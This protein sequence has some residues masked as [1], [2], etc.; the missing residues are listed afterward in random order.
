MTP[1]ARLEEAEVV[2]FSLLGQPV[3]VRSREPKVFSAYRRLYRRFPEI[4]HSPEAHVV[5][6]VKRADDD[7]HPWEALID[8]LPN[9]RHATLG[10]AMKRA[11]RRCC[12]H[13][14][15]HTPEVIGLHAAT[16]A[17]G[18]EFALI[19]GDSGS[20][21]TTLTLTL[22]ARGYPVDG[23]DIALL[24]PTT[25]L[26]RGMPRCFHLDD[27][28]IDLLAEQGLVVREREI[29]EGFLTPRDVG[30]GE[31]LLRPVKALFFLQPSDLPQPAVVH[32]SHADAVARLNS[33]TGPRL[34]PASH[35]FAAYASMLRGAH[36][37]ELRRGPL[38]TT[39][40]LVVDTVKGLRGSA[41]P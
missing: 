2:A 6:I 16:I 33:Q 41:R 19:T 34:V 32:L 40:D 5:E 35:V 25:G 13:A 39:A 3:A 30:D 31:M 10:E 22:S 9:E 21:K 1:L 29:C 37:F 4:P 18:D 38:G 8:H 27:P 17:F 24:D 14:L 26:V 23:D 20:G 15:L 36:C 28:S 12:S 11:E 7:S